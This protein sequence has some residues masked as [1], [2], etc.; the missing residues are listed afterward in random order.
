MRRT[1]STHTQVEVQRYADVQLV[2]STF[3]KGSSGSLTRI[4]DSDIL[5]E[6]SI[7]I[8]RSRGECLFCLLRVGF[9]PHARP[10]D[11]SKKKQVQ[12]RRFSSS[13]RLESLRSNIE[14][15]GQFPVIPCPY[16]VVA[17]TFS[18]FVNDRDR[19]KFCCLYVNI[20]Q[21]T[22]NIQQ[23]STP[24]FVLFPDA[25]NGRGW[26]WQCRVL[27]APWRKKPKQ[28]THIHTHTHMYT[29]IV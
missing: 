27:T 9:H 7:P 16:F 11:H 10:F 1:R 29:H 13:K 23:H 15:S 22:F 14:P 18:G 8:Q 25:H 26:C 24:F 6:V 17:S 4:N 21:S 2:E 5:Q 28:H 12:H 20:Q 3:P 19:H